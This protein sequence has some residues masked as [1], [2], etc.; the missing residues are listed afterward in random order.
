[1]IDDLILFTIYCHS[2]NYCSFDKMKCLVLSILVLT[3]ATVD[4]LL[5]I[6]RQGNL[7]PTLLDVTNPDFV[8]LILNLPSIKVDNDD[9]CHVRL[10][11]DIDWNWIEISFH[12]HYKHPK[13]DD[14]EVLY[15]TYITRRE[16]RTRTII[17]L[18]EYGCSADN[19][20]KKFIVGHIGWLVTT[21]QSQLA[22]HIT[23]LF[24]NDTKEPGNNLRI[25]IEKK[26]MF[27]FLKPRWRFSK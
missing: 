26:W 15:G 24:K 20:D 11:V 7:N 17:N 5:C 14:E 6:R 8:E 12:K 3:C 25:I 9:F 2:F 10:E 19:C 13:L 23:Q 22:T 21:K 27:H 16:G 1:M 4:S 18:L